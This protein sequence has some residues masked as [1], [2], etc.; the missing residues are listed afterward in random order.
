M[1]LNQ[2]IHGFVVRRKQPLPE[3]EA[4]LWEMDHPGSGARLV[5]LD[6][7]EENKTFGIAFQTQPWDD[8]G[9]F[10]ILE[11]S[12]LCGSRRYPVKEP[13]VELLKSSMNT[14]LNAITFPDKTF[15]PVSSR[16]HQDL[17]N[18]MRIYMD[19]VLHPLLH[20]KPEIFYQEGWHYE[21]SPEGTLSRKGVVYNEM[22]GA[23]SSP[24]RLLHSA[25][26]RGLFPDTCYRWVSG[27]HPDAIPHL[28]YQE[29]AAAHKRLYH[30]SNSYLFLDGAVHL[31]EILAILD[32]EFL[33]EYQPIQP[34]APIAM[35]KPVSGGCQT[36]PYELSAQEALEGRTRLGEGYVACTFADRADL[37]A[38]TVLADTLCGDNQAPLKHSLLSAGLAKDVELS[39][40][41]GIQQPWMLLDIKDV[42][43]DQ[44]QA[45]LDAAHK[46][47]RDTAEQGLDQERILA[48]L[49]NLEFQLRQ[50]DYGSYPQ[51]IVFGFQVLESWLYGGQPE[52][53]LLVG[54]IFEQLRKKC[55]EG[56]FEQL[57][58]RV[59]LE[60]PHSYKVI[61]E[62][63]H[64]L[65]QQQ[66]H[67]EA[68]ALQTLY[69][70][71]STEQKQQA[72]TLQNQIN[73]W[74][75]T[76]DNPEDLATIPLLKLEEI[77]SQPQQLPTDLLDCEGLPVLFHQ[78]TTGGIA[79]LNLYFAADDLT[80]AEL[81]AASLLCELVTCLDLADCPV[82]ELQKRIRAQL[83]S[84]GWGIEPYGL[85]N[86]PE[87]CRTFLCVSLSVLE[88][89]LP[90]A[91]ELMQQVM[92]TTQWNDP[93][94]IR[95]L[96]FQNRSVRFQQL[97]MNGHRSA[98]D[99]AASSFSAESL[100]RE[101]ADGIAYYQW[102]KALTDDFD[103]Q[104][105]AVIQQMEQLASRLFTI[106]RLTLSVTTHQ[107][108]TA[109]TAAALLQ[110]LLPQ[111]IHCRSLP[112]TVHPIGKALREGVVVPSDVAFAAMS[113]PFAP[114][115]EGQARVMG[116]AVSLAYLWNAV[117]V[118]G[119][120]YGAG[121]MLRNNGMAGFYSYRDP[122]ALR[123]L[124]CYRQAPAFVEQLAQADVTGYMIGTVGDTDPLLT[125]RMKGKNADVFHWCGI[126]W[127][128]Q[129]QM[130]QQILD[131]EPSQLAN[132]KTAV[133]KLVAQASVCVVG[134]RQQ[135]E[136]CASQL[137]S[138][139]EL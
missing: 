9:I 52:L 133:D 113:G 73:L 72:E 70:G 67:Q 36:L 74:Q 48:C 92:Q 80:A 23:F 81:H 27:G 13:F 2:N 8:T 6:R 51:G 26:Q 109:L 87:R 86:Q 12:V 14:F 97:A 82:P 132:L 7:A 31:E 111:G 53:H 11:H 129:C 55:R 120:A 28:T 56:Y 114:A 37:I 66:A 35:Q 94:K 125:P 90:K 60:Q 17:L 47:L 62:P 103:S 33:S 20:T 32:Q 54:D 131:T 76:P 10:H 39:L 24:D 100:V 42:H 21:V 18:L 58:R 122:S 119:G 136:E 61:L 96:V 46:A 5:W 89:K 49:D 112:Q 43:Q 75:N 71:W 108:D 104:I 117:R 115:L 102:L 16:N 98:L 38:L 45:A 41:D 30:P 22:K 99:R 95:E 68:Q 40:Q 19:A 57:I 1:N 93:D 78:Q 3:L 85:A 50:R 65:G 29:F 134:S 138:I 130:R 118:Q 64:G 34:P 126:D 79:H 25:I 63:C 110:K 4:T 77:A 83:G 59:F 123:T 106:G 121:M 128:Q 105:A 116:N 101:Q 88:E 84:L 135:V 107:K 91:L 124:D 44:Q 15:Y 137:D 69:Q 139:L 127:Q